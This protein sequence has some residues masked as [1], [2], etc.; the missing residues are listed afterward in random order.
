MESFEKVTTQHSFRQQQTCLFF[1]H[2]FY[3]KESNPWVLDTV[4]DSMT[5]KDN[6]RWKPWLSWNKRNKHVYF[7]VFSCWNVQQWLFPIPSAPGWV[8]FY[9]QQFPILLFLIKLF[10]FFLF[11]AAQRVIL[12]FSWCSGFKLFLLRSFG[13]SYHH[14]FHKTRIKKTAAL[15]AECVFF[16]ILMYTLWP[17]K[18]CKLLGQTICRCYLYCKR[19]WK[20]YVENSYIF[21]RNKK[22]CLKS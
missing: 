7:S 21:L 16:C 2:V 5:L 18:G 3:I 13:Q 4:N 9:K 6:S 19:F 8:Y 20:M 10:L 17:S 1:C 22:W 15:A 12:Q 14:E 11:K